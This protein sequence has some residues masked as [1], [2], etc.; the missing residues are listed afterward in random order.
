MQLEVAH[1]W[2]AVQRQA[3]RRRSVVV[4]RQRAVGEE[5]VGYSRGFT[6][7]VAV[8]VAAAAVCPPD[9]EVGS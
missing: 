4:L 3:R 2:V 9:S 8:R 1:A 6:G 7:A 5:L